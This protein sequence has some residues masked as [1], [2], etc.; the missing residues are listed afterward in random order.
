[1]DPSVGRAYLILEAYVQQGRFND[2]L[3]NL[4]QWRR[5]GDRPWIWAFEAYVYGRS[6][7]AVRARKALRQLE[8]A[9]RTWVPDP[10]PLLRAVSQLL[11]P[12]KD[13][14]VWFSLEE[15][16]EKACRSGLHQLRNRSSVA[17]A[18]LGDKEKWLASLQEA[19]RQHTNLPTSFKVDPLYDALR[20]DPRFQELL[21]GAGFDR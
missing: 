20:S 21:R 6:G 1:V 11:W 7:N 8:K 2:A 15:N 9:H 12:D 4:E 18:G 16:H 17:Y 19:Y 5:L 3:A 14:E 10:T 13:G